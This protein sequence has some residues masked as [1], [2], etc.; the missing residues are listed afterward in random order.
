MKHYYYKQGKGRASN[1]AAQQESTV[2]LS[3]SNKWDCINCD[4]LELR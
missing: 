4:G 1:A 3:D 2:D